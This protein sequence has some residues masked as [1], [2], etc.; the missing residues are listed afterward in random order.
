MCATMDAKAI[1]GPLSYAQMEQFSIR[2]SLHAIGGIMLT[3]HRQPVSISKFQLQ[4]LPKKFNAVTTLDLH[5]NY[6]WTADEY[7]KYP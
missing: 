1:K 6:V 3:A 7:D 5:L 2:K 4:Y